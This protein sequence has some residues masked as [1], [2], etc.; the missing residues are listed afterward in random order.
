M[1]TLKKLLKFSAYGKHRNCISQP[2]H[3]SEQHTYG[4]STTTGK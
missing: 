3:S 1:E 4:I 2:W